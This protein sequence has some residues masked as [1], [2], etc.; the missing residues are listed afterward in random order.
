MY[1]PSH[2]RIMLYIDDS[3]KTA[4]IPS[5]KTLFYDDTEVILDL[6]NVIARRRSSDRDVSW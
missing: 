4:S 5:T 6:L 1:S 2:S 3:A